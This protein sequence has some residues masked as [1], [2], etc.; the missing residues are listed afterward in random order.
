[1]TADR[2][3][4]EQE[5]RNLRIAA[6]QGQVSKSV[7]QLPVHLALG[8]CRARISWTGQHY[9]SQTGSIAATQLGVADQKY[10]TVH[11]AGLRRHLS[12]V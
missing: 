11:H 2:L 12:S 7:L 4:Q 10:D 8:C 1:M 6:R 9:C 3:R 5:H